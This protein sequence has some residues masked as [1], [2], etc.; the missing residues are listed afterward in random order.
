MRGGGGA[1]SGKWQDLTLLIIPKRNLGLRITLTFKHFE[2]PKN[3]FFRE[4]KRFLVEH[5][6]KKTVKY[7]QGIC[8]ELKKVVSVLVRQV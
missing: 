6:W 5:K 3:I 7:I 1:Q 8:E 2:K 4:K